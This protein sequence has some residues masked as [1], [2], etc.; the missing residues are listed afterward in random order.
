[1]VKLAA[2]ITVEAASTVPVE[3]STVAADSMAAVVASTAVAAATAVVTG[4]FD[5]AVRIGRP[6]AKA[7]GRFLFC[8]LQ[9]STRSRLAK[10][11]RSMSFSN[12]RETAHPSRIERCSSV[13]EFWEGEHG[14]VG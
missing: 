13:I 8:S 3:V 12:S 11:H 9:R 6:A 10:N 1:M 2:A 4:K 14:R 7:V 5:L